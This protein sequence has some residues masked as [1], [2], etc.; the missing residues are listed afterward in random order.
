MEIRPILN[1]AHVRLF[2][3]PILDLADALLQIPKLVFVNLDDPQTPVIVGI[4][5][6]LDA[7]GLACARIP[8]E[9]AVVGRPYIHG[10]SQL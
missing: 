9:Q 10:R 7:G 3:I 4:G 2:V 5:N 6:G 1:I 8:K